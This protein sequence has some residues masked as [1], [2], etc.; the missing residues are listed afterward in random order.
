MQPTNTIALSMS[1]PSTGRAQRWRQP[2]VGFSATR[3]ILFATQLHFSGDQRD[4][5]L[6]GATGDHWLFGCDFAGQHSGDIQ[7]GLDHDRAGM[8]KCFLSVSHAGFGL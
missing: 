6:Y 8:V 3:G 7:S 1:S 2:I 5:I 4:R